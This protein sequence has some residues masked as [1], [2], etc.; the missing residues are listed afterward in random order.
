LETSRQVI[1]LRP[2]QPT[3]YDVIIASLAYMGRLDEARDVLKRNS[4][5]SVEQR[6]RYEQRPPWLRP[7]DH[8]LRVEGLRL[9]LSS[10]DE[11]SPFVRIE[12][13]SGP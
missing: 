6:Q 8:A 4:P 3:A 1:R 5:H 9:A 13:S 10:G 12:N 2:G 7:E 11:Y